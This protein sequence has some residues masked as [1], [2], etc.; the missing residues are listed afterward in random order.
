MEV[1]LQLHVHFLLI[2]YVPGNHGLTG[3]SQL[4]VVT[5]ILT[6]WLALD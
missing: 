4:Q 6:I 1:Q 2:Y 3:V 5:L